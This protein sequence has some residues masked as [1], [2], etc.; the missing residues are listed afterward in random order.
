MKTLIPLTVPRSAQATYLRNFRR[1]TQGTGNLMLFAGDQKIE[2]LNN[3][4]AGPEIS[5]DDNHPEHLFRI[6]SRARVGVFASQLGLI[7]NHAHRYRQVNY[8]I[9]L[10]S[11]TDLLP[12][13]SKD[14]LSTCLNTID[15][16]VNF[17]K[18]SKLRIVGVGYTLYPGSAFEDQMLA[19]AG[20]LI[21]EAHQHGLLVVLWI[22]LRG[23]AIKK[24]KDATLL[25]GAAGIAAALGADFV[26]INYPDTPTK[27]KL[28]TIIQAAGHTGVIFSGGESIDTKKFLKTLTDQIQAGARGNATGRNIHQKSLDQAVNMANAISSVVINHLS[29]DQAYL[30]SQGQAQPPSRPFKF[31]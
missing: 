9:K 13:T 31:F 10:N 29:A 14:P 18:T 8:L 12:T 7:A 23:Q 3:D 2:H 15:Q 25:A 17:Q 22:Y 4:F 30:I 27:D 1:A 6:A 5:S 16:V 11:K 19:E 20:R 21:H 24:P 26:K 28:H